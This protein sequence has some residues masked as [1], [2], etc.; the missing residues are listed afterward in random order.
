MK[1]LIMATRN[2]HKLEEV[3][4]MLQGKYIV[5]GLDDIGCHE[6]I[7]E[8]S[9]T[10]EGNAL[11]KARYV[12][13]H[14]GVDCFADDTG[15]EVEALE[16]E[17]GVYTARFGQLNGYGDSHDTNANVDCL[18]D[19]MSGKENRKAQFRTVIALIQ[20]GREHLFEGIVQ[21][22]I[23]PERRGER[24]FGYDPIF[25]PEEMGGRSFSQMSAEDKNEVSHRGRAVRKLCQFLTT[26]CI[27]LCCLLPLSASAQTIG[28]WQVFPSYW[29]ATQN[30]IVGKSVYSLTNGN[31]L[32]YDTEDTS[33][34]TFD[35]LNTLSDTH[36]NHIGYSSQ[37]KRIILVYD[38]A[39][40][41][42][43]DTDNNV[44]NMAS[45]RDKVIAGKSVNSLYVE[46]NTAYLATGFGF[47]EVDMQ[48]GTFQNTY[49][50]GLNTLC[51][52]FNDSLLFLG[53]D[54]G[55]YACRK[56]ANMHQISN[57][58]K[59]NDN[60]Y[61]QLI[62]FN[63]VL[64]GREKNDLATIHAEDGS[65]QIFHQG[66][67]NLFQF[68]DG[69]LIWADDKQIKTCS[70]LDNITTVSY[71]NNWNDV[72][73]DGKRWWV[74]QGYDGL[75]AYR[76]ADNSF[77]VEVGPIQPNSPKT[78]LFYRMAWQGD[79][80]LVA[81]GI[82]NIAGTKF[83][84]TAMYFQDG[85]WTNFQEMENP[86]KYTKFNLANTT[87]LV[88]DPTDDTHHF[89]SF[90]RNG[91]C[92][93]RNAKSSAF[94]NC[95]NSPIR[96]ILPDAEQYYNYCSCSGLQYDTDGNLWMLN[97]ETDTIVRVRRSNGKW[98]SL[99]YSEI[100]GTNMADD[101]LMHSSGL[102]F[103][104]CRMLTN[105]G[106][107][108]FDTNGTFNSTRDDKHRLRSSITNQDGTSYS[109][110]EFYCLT[111][112]LDGRVWCGTNLGLFVID[113]A[114]TWFDDNF[115]FQQIKIARND[116]S[117]LADYLLNGVSV[118]CIAIDGG[119]RKWVGTHSDGVYLL[120]A[121]GTEMIHHF[122]S[123]D[124][125]LLSD[126][127]HHIAVHPTTGEVMIA[128]DAG[129]CSYISD[130]TQAADNL[131]KDNIVVYPNPVKPDYT[132]S[133][134]VRGLTMDSEVKILSSAGQSIYSGVST[135]G[136]F[137]WNGCNAHGKRVSS[138]VYHVVANNAEGKKAIITRIIVIK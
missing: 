109:P 32:S 115:C 137:T 133:I 7:P 78:D 12:H 16:G 39:N 35:C 57:W 25:A 99:Y 76:F 60:T 64:V 66:S 51:L 80:L 124:S 8:T 122:T 28:Q 5:Q 58:K 136:T 38:N 92:E 89:A 49:Q 34:R 103:L 97:S 26:L 52:A 65:S 23:L 13:T 110:D 53:T 75:Y 54:Q 87:S 73:I 114:T 72:H 102:I 111:E 2:E 96:S 129:L 62:C 69:Q 18:I 20:E 101:Y 22:E 86:A 125:P 11:Q 117:G 95:D 94:Y 85:Q 67:V 6:D 50:L 68:T 44:Q 31:L 19:K 93:Y 10:L 135:G 120:S 63:G 17:P 15:L 88:Q 43:M 55:L 79:R 126:M 3:R 90:C 100:A 47:V 104:N 29:N 127:V 46:G 113:D 48:E 77:T 116:G 91:L 134:V 33:I 121:D 112:D 83:T 40:I 21:G 138:G 30:I 130:A 14:Y 45:L 42:L 118:N 98:L 119:N 1:E 59:L 41:D 123:A 107:F 106:F 108:C 70:K 84:P 36:I 24:G 74:S 81:G 4:Q 56:S 131:D 37:A 132:G 27:L 61:I 9:D 82:N 71:Q 105:R 128:T